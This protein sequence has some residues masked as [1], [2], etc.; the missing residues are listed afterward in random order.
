[1]V[2]LNK[3]LV[4]NSMKD[5]VPRQH[6]IT[7]VVNTTVTSHSDLESC[8]RTSGEQTFKDNSSVGHGFGNSGED[9]GLT[10]VWRSSAKGVT[11]V[12]TLYNNR[13]GRIV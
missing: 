11:A 10:M 9:S 12:P 3:S 4:D 8:P 6:P 7:V 1:M 5:E 2:A 13:G